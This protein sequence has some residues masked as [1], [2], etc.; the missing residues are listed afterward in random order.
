VEEMKMQVSKPVFI[1]H[2]S[3]M[4][5]ISNNFYSKFLNAY[6]KSILAPRA[7][8]VISAHWQTQG[9]HITGNAHPGQIYDFYGFPDELYKLKYS[10]EGSAEVASEIEDD[11]LGIKIDEKRGID[12]AA[13]AVV[14]HMYPE[15]TIPLLEMSLDVKKTAKEHFSLGAKLSKYSER[16]ILFI[17]SG[18][19]VHNLRDISFNEEEKPFEWAIESDRW[20]KEK[21]E[22]NDIAKLLDYEKSMPNVRRAIPTNEHYIPLFYILGMKKE[23]T[24]INTIYDEI[25]NGSIS[26]RSIEIS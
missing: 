25:Q 23:D 14:R 15:Q 20:I 18:N 13:W 3:P 17:G 16:G 7:I 9:S 12:H 10:P 4:N 5:A 6:A 26:M 24:K 1:G 8:V 22:D 21:L 11:G 2:G 19:V